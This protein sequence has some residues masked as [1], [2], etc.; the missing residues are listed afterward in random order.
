MAAKITYITV[1]Q[2]MAHVYTSLKRPGLVMLL[3]IG[4]T[5]HT[6][7]RLY[8]NKQ[9]KIKQRVMKTYA[10]A[11]LRIVSSLQNKVGKLGLFLC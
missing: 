2:A 11:P 3:S 8:L 10:T 5:P 6:P 9:I 4:N 7:S 1:T